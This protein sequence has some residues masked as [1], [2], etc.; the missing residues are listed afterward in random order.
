MPDEGLY[1]ICHGE[2]QITRSEYGQPRH[3]A[4][5]G[6]GDVFGEM[7]IINSSPRNATATALTDCGFFTVNQSNFQHRVNQLDPVM[8]GAFRVFVLTIR[9]LMT[10][11]DVMA[12]QMQHM[13]Q[14]MQQVPVSGAVSEVG[15]GSNMS[16]NAEANDGGGLV[17]GATRKLSH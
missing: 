11:R 9:D 12:E 1:F 4:K 14:Q 17:D 2:V 8:R 7:G 15:G 6:A 3:L 5:L 13:V 10:Q 16:A